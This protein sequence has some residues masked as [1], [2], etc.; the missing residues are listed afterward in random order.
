[1]LED[2]GALLEDENRG[3]PDR[4]HVDGLKGGVQYED[5]AG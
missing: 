3:T 5:P 4:A 2:L 1:M